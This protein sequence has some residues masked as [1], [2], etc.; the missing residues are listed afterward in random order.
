MHTST[1]PTRMQKLSDV[2]NAILDGADACMLSGETAIGDY[3]V[4]SVAMMN[5]I[6]L[7]TESSLV[8]MPEYGSPK[9]ADGVQLVT[10]AVVY[11]AAR[12]ADR[13][14]AKLVVIATRTGNTA[15]IKAKQRDYIPTVGVSR[16]LSTLRQ[17]CLF[18]ELFHYGGCHS[19]GEQLR[20]AVEKWG[21]K[22]CCLT[23]TMPFSSPV[24]RLGLWP[25]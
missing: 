3:P 8:D 10:S 7:N 22:M 18:W 12:I 5:R 13:L 11:G 4:E 16:N 1:R 25:R 14:E 24:V 2:A 9:V 17:M 21:R 23:V 15:R 6:M 19:S 20:A